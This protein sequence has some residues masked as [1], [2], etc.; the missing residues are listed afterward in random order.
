MYGSTQA[1]CVA[2]LIAAGVLSGCQDETTESALPDRPDEKLIEDVGKPERIIEDTTPQ[3]GSGGRIP[4]YDATDAGEDIVDAEEQQ[5]PQSE[6]DTD[7][8]K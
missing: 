8:S 1:L 7:K 3:T 2:L 6:D 5:V 4:G